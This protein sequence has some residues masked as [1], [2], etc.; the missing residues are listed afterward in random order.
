MRISSKPHSSRPDL[1]TTSHDQVQLRFQATLIHRM[2]PRPAATIPICSPG[3]FLLRGHLSGKDDER[4]EEDVVTYMIARLQNGNSDRVV[5][6]ADD[7]MDS[8]RPAIV[9]VVQVEHMHSD[10]SPHQSWLI[11]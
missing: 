1:R 2:R 4:G 5:V 7:K 9:L 10:E 6:E 3:P 11:T 8:P